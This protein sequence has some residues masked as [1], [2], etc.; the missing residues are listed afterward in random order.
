MLGLA[1]RKESDRL[2]RIAAPSERGW[3]SFDN[4]LSN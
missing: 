4:P 2:K 3:C 1:V